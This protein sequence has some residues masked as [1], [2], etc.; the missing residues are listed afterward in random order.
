M[1]LFIDLFTHYVTSQFKYETPANH[2]QVC[3]CTIPLN[4]PIDIPIIGTTYST[5]IIFFIG[6]MGTF[7]LLFSTIVN[8]NT[9]YLVTCLSFTIYS[10]FN[11]P[12]IIYF[13]IEPNR[14]NLKR[15]REKRN[16]HAWTRN[17]RRNWE[18]SHAQDERRH[19]NI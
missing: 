4:C 13:A 1:S 3:T 8:S 15:E 2:N 6:S 19:L 16:N 12:M 11:M 5:L 9:M 7:P 18:I 10:I 17:Q 14:T